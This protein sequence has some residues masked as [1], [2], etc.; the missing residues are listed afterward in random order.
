MK[1]W[2]GELISTTPLCERNLWTINIEHHSFFQNSLSDLSNF[3]ETIHFEIKLDIYD[4]SF[5]NLLLVNY[6]TWIKKNDYNKA[7]IFYFWISISFSEG[8][9]SKRMIITK[10][11]FLIFGSQ[12]LSVKD[13]MLSTIKNFDILTVHYTQNI[14][15]C[16][17]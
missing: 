13:M 9:E 14:T 10:L 8:Y 3:F 1:W 15:T 5:W 4:S 16:S 7:L 12:F 6:S 11:W 2:G 17:H